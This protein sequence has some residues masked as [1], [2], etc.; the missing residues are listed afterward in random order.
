MRE[1]E[2]LRL[3]WSRSVP[4]QAVTQSQETALVD[5]VIGDCR[6]PDP[7]ARPQR[8]L[9]SRASLCAKSRA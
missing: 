4:G 2:S 9:S 7:H 1:H 3:T 5:N 6:M 8:R